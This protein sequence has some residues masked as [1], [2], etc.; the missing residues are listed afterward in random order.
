MASIKSGYS[1]YMQEHRIIALPAGARFQEARST[2]LDLDPATSFLLD[3]LHIR[4]AL[5]DN[6]CA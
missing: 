4:T 1:R 2:A 3:M 6:L 5:S